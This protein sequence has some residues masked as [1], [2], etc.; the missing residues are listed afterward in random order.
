MAG[1]FEFG[2]KLTDV[3]EIAP[4]VEVP[5]T[6]LSAALREVDPVPPRDQTYLP[7]MAETRT[8]SDVPRKLIEAI[9]EYLSEDLCCDHSVGI[10]MCSAAGIVQELHLA[11]EGKLTCHKCGGEGFTWNEARHR[12][13]CLRL[14]KKHGYKT[15]QEAAGI[16]GDSPGFDTCPECT[17]AGHVRIG[18][19]V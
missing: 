7:R 3:Q 12:D 5:D 18:A 11:L 8:T 1:P 17:G 10:C 4:W 2:A 15:W 13:E 9:I 6:L 19:S 14:A 16:Y